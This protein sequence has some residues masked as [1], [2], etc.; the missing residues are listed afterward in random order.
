[1]KVKIKQIHAVA[2]WTWA[3]NDDVCGICQ[4][5]LDGC[6]PSS[7]FPGDD[8]PVVWGACSHAFHLECVTRWLQSNNTCPM[9]RREWQF[10]SGNPKDEKEKKKK[11]KKRR[12]RR[13]GGDQGGG[14][15]AGAAAAR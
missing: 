14:D 15:A 9:C 2:T 13:G 3:A 6:A 4:N 8:S 12:R 10:A 1:M 5:P 7:E 11:K